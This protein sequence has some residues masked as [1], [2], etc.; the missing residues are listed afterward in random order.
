MCHQDVQPWLPWSALTMLVKLLAL[1]IWIFDSPSSTI[2][3]EDML[4]T[5]YA[6]PMPVQN[7]SRG[8]PDQVLTFVLLITC[9][10]CRPRSSAGEPTLCQRSRRL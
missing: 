8:L 6:P 7:I 4:S 9:V 2:S 1:L 5:S 10:L 3:E